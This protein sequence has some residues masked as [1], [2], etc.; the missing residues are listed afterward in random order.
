MICG[1][2]EVG[3]GCLAGRVVA[4]AVV[5]TGAVPTG[6]RDSKA[7]SRTAR[8]RLEPAIRAVAHVTLGSASVEEVDRLNVLQ[9]TMLAMVRAYEGL[10]AGLPVS[11]V[12]VDGDRLPPFATGTPARAVVG[13]D[14]LVPEIAAA[15]ICAKVARD[16]EM[17][18]LHGLHPVYRWDS[19]AGYGSPAHLAALQ[20]HGPTAHHRTTFAPVRAVILRRSLP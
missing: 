13:G 17:H 8:L 18:E 1:I 15:S 6:V 10:P 20:E 16:A 12:L 5:L 3:R 2:D 7:V 4:C 9:A 19:N 11:E 14:A